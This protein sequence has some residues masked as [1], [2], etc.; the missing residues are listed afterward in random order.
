MLRA[1]RAS[2]VFRSAKGSGRGVL[3]KVDVGLVK[4]VEELEERVEKAEVELEK[5]KVRVKG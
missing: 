4:R 5:V 2:A 3:V 1:G